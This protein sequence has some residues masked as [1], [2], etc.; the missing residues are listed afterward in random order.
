MAGVSGGTEQQPDH[1]DES[2]Q[3]RLQGGVPMDGQRGRVHVEPPSGVVVR[4]SLAT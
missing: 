2:H 4:P 1:H 3:T